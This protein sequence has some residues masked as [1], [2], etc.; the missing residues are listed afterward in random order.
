MNSVKTFATS[1]VFGFFLISGTIGVFGNAF[2]LDITDD[3]VESATQAERSAESAVDIIQDP[4]SIIDIE[5][6]ESLTGEV[7][8]IVTDS[9]L[10]TNT[11]NWQDN[12]EEFAEYFDLHYNGQT[13][14]EG[15]S[16]SIENNQT[17]SRN[18]DNAEDQFLLPGREELCGIGAD[19]SL[20]GGSNRFGDSF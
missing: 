8:I 15:A 10:R 12:P 3:A 1:V 6:S 19:C 14:S 4:A 16:S 7:V 20:T 18:S 2:V 9:N 11:Y 5:F 17:E 13:E